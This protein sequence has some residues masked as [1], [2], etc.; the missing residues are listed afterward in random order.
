MLGRTPTFETYLEYK[1]TKGVISWS[2]IQCEDP[3]YTNFLN[4]LIEREA[5]DF[6]WMNVLGRIPRFEEYMIYWETVKD[7]GEDDLN[8]EQLSFRWVL[9]QGGQMSEQ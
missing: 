6:D 8:S 1:D 4:F 7:F 5:V 2:E 3:K 9:E